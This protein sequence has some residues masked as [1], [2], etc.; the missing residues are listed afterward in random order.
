MGMQKIKGIVIAEKYMNDSDKI[1]T[2]L[3]EFNFS[4]DATFERF[5]FLI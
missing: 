4:F 1:L 5:S 2:I 3:T